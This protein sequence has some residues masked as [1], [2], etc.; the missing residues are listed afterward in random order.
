MVNK[1]I[2]ILNK[3]IEVYGIESQIEMII[4]ECAEL[5]FALQKYK[6]HIQTNDIAQFVSDIQQEIA[7]VKIMIYQAEQIFG[8]DEVEIFLNN[9]IKRLQNRLKYEKGGQNE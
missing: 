8:E 9:K 5:I 1:N 4:E 2:E 6:R 7:D 3:A